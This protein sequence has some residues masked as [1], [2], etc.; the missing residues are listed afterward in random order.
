MKSLTWISTTFCLAVSGT[1]LMGGCNHEESHKPS[2]TP[3]A[4]TLSARDSAIH[5]ISMARCERDERCNDFGP[6]KRYESLIACEDDRDREAREN[7][8]EC[9]RGV[10]QKRLDECV[11]AIRAE[12]CGSPLDTL[13]RLMACRKSPCIE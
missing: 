8:G 1:G 12:E 4:G 2:M 13:E 9:K 11:S 3:A 10:D 5:Q 6:G 7:A